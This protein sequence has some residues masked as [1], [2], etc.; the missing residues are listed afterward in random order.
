MAAV[1]NNKLYCY[2]VIILGVTLDAIYVLLISRGRVGL[3]RQYPFERASQQIC[4]L[5]M[6]HD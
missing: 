6:K 3:Q 4:L 1:G 2:K 5:I